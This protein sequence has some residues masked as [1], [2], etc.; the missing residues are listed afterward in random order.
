[1]KLLQES[2]HSRSIIKGLKS[3][4]KT[5]GLVPTMGALHQGHISLVRESLIAN[6]VTIVTIFVNPIQFNNPEDFEKYP[7]SIQDDLDLLEDLGVDY[8]FMPAVSEMYAEDPIINLSFGHLEKVMEGKHRPGHFSGVAIIVAKLFNILA[9]DRAYFGQKD[10]Q[11]LKI[12]E[13]MV[14]DLS[15]DVDLIMMPIIREKNGLAMS[16]R[17]RRLSRQ[18]QE[19]ASQIS[20][21][22]IMAHDI[23]I[24]GGENSEAV[25]SAKVY[26]E[27]YQE[28]NTEYLEL[29]SYKDLR[30]VTADTQTN[31]LVLC[32]AGYVE[33]IRLID[34]VIVS[35]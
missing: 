11:Q 31:R 29:V 7:N 33:G 15:M 22:L 20:S 8:V 16:S 3:A 18:G 34:N 13:Q 19:I 23:L 6:N 21:S 14:S 1:M 35:K 32:F 26:L 30:P 27:Q 2:D 25:L 28:I 17:N 12:I 4:N 9:P 10:L 24:K 5:I